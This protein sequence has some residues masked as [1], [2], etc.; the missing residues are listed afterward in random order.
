MLI[1]ALALAAVLQTT[2]QPD[3]AQTAGDLQAMY[4]EITETTLSGTSADDFDT[5]HAVFFT[6][7]WTFTDK[8]GGHHTW[9][10]VREE[11]IR[12]WLERPADTMR[13]VIRRAELHDGSAVTDVSSIVIKVVVDTD[14]KYGGRGMS[15]RVA[16]STPMRDRW[17][18]GEYGWR[19]Q[20]REQ[21]GDA[22][23]FVDKLPPEM[24]NPKGPITKQ[25]TRR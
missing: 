20:S 15:H 6:N 7:D 22:R 23:V 17:V 16:E 11:T 18:L 1:A 3:P 10:D 19:V 9:R 12:S 13:D 25:L 4:D 24:E 5:F 21:V 14:G 8:S 2:P